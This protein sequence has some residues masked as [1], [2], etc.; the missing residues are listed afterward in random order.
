MR[1]SSPHMLVCMKRRRMN[2]SRNT[3]TL[4]GNP[5]RLG[6][7]YDEADGLLYLSGAAPDDLDAFDIPNHFWKNTKHS[8]EVAR[9]A[10]LT[11]LQFRL[12]WQEDS[13]YIYIGLPT[14][15]NSQP[16]VAFDMMTGGTT[17]VHE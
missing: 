8:C 14:V 9:C 13:K 2:V 17:R 16:A 4:L 7:W 11:A 6:F 3:I 12:G 10:F 15:R 5:K 1:I